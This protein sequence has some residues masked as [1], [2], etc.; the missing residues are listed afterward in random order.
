MFYLL[1]ARGAGEDV[2]ARIVLNN[3]VVPERAVSLTI[4]TVGGVTVRISGCR[5][6]LRQLAADLFNHLPARVAGDA[7]RV[8]VWLGGVNGLTHTTPLTRFLWHEPVLAH[9]GS[10]RRMVLGARRPRQV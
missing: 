10:R 3:A 2:I 4:A 7:V 9:V 1:R 8:G 6:L 5:R